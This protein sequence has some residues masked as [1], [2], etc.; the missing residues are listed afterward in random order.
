MATCPFNFQQILD[1]QGKLVYTNVGISMMPLL[2]QRRDL[3]VIT[4]KPEGRLRLWDVPLYYR[5]HTGQ[6]IMHRV[7]WV[8]RHS[9]VMCGDNQWRP[10]FGV[11]DD[12]ILG[13]LEGVTRVDRAGLGADEQASHYLAIRPT[14]EHPHVSLKYRLYVFVWCFFYPIRACIFFARDFYYR[15][16][17]RLSKP[18]HKS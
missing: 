3:L 12:Q 9:Y 14:E 5:P 11:R 18:S 2:R 10:E 7:L 8:G 6:Y 16:R 13:V 1:E 4:R 15:L 17:N